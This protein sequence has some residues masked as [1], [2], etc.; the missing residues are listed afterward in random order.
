[1]IKSFRIFLLSLLAP[2]AFQAHAMTDQE[3]AVRDI[4]RGIA[5]ADATWEKCIRGTAGNLYMAD[6]YDTADGSVSG[7]SDVWPLTAAIE[8]HCS[9]LEALGAAMETSPALYDENFQRYQTRLEQLI[10]NLGYYRGTYRLQSYASSREWSPFAVPRA[11]QR[12]KADV[13]G[14]LNVYDDQMWLCRELIRAWRITNK[15]EYLDLATYLAEYVIDG[16][17]CWRDA[18]GMEYGG[19]TWGPGYNSKHSCS[20]GP[21]IQPLVWLAEIYDGTGETTVY[22]F[23]DEENKVKKETRPRSAHYLEF[24]RK[25]YDW[26]KDNLADDSGV[27][28]D[29]KGGVS[30]DIE[31]SRGYRQHVDCGGAGGA[32][33][34]YNTGTMIGGGVSL[35][36]VTSDPVLKQ[37][38]DKT[39]PASLGKFSRYVRQ[40]GSYEFTTDKDAMNG[41]NTWFNNVLMRSYVDAE[42]VVE[43]NTVRKALDSFQ[44]NLDY[45]FENHNRENMLPIHLLDGWGDETKT[46][47]F[48]QFTF[49]SEYALL[50]KR[51]LEKESASLADILIDREQV[52]DS[53]YTLG[54]VYLGEFTAVGADLAGGIYIVGNR[55]I[56]VR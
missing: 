1:M 18:S 43:G 31:V 30:G 24:A 49:A 45:A 17:D 36:R 12:G 53:V 5:I 35:F 9:L 46:K 40:H 13:R 42:S 11:N 21:I 7:P 25:V 47:G 55:K 56:S 54:G 33:Y 39:V 14:I 20:N 6:V 23:R 37:D 4:Q 27:Y 26:Q 41:F 51:L 48:H 10:D 50:A 52:S 15:R 29:M 8:A 32:F 3:L 34:S 19:I 16:W 2:L 44:K 38:L 28:W 22:Y